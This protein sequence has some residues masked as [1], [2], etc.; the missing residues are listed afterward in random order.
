LPK[1]QFSSPEIQFS[2]TAFQLSPTAFCFPQRLSAFLNGFPI[3]LNSFPLSKKS[4]KIYLRRQVS[5]RL[6]FE[7]RISCHL[8]SKLRNSRY[9][10]YNS[11]N[12]D[13]DETTRSF[14]NNVSFE[15]D[16]WKKIEECALGGLNLEDE[17]HQDE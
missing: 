1:I 9:N 2:S 17:L 10:V 13:N 8:L 7:L 12:R 5:E 11:P 16:D 6:L 15:V 4:K 14:D 3:F